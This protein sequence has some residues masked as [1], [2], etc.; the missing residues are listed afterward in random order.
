MR[1]V[2]KAWDRF[3]FEPQ[4][5]SS[6]A[7]FRIAIGAITFAWT[8]SLLP[9]LGAFFSAHGIEPSPPA[10]PPAG[11]WGVLN[12]FP[13]YTVVLVLYGLLLV[14]SVCLVVGYRTRLASVLAFVAIMSF[15]HRST[16]IWNSGDDLLRIM[17]FFLMF[18]PAGASLSLDR[19]RTARARFWEFPARAPWALRL[20][21]IQISVVY[22]S[23]V[24]VK[25]HGPTWRDGTA[26]SY[27]VRLEDFLRFPLPHALAHSLLFSSVMTYSTI[28]V[29]LMI[30]VLVWNRAA[31]PLVLALGVGLHFGLGSS[32]RL[33]FFGEI[34]ITC[35]LAF[36]S[37]TAAA[38]GVLAVRD[39]VRG[40]AARLRSSAAMS[41]PE[42]V[43][44]TW[45]AR[46]ARVRRGPG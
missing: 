11:W 43:P 7:V 14:A 33:G 3:W 40:W 41:R 16:S 20:V 25:L 5:T 4:A 44:G 8:L 2:A 32:L 29:E 9:D 6:L 36:L 34:M 38:A 23:A 27:A 18:A 13:S 31:R 1:T 46:L 30:A 10:H 17:M 35:Y 26:V 28:A 19:L 22:L 12:I 42:L 45:F 24:W 21:Q 15:Q 37:P 39:G